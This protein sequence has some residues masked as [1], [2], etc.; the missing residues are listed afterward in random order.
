MF[1]RRNVTEWV[2]QVVVI[3]SGIMLLCGLDDIS[4]VRGIGG[5][6]AEG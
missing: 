1:W 6:E 4:S 3:G 5:L 2:V